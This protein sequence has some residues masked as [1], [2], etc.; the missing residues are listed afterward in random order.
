[1]VNLG[2]HSK[3]KSLDL[4][5]SLKMMILKVMILNEVFICALNA[6]PFY[7]LTEAVATTVIIGVSF[8]VSLS[9]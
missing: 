6:R 8:N 5:T 1:M 9:V 2:S 3:K 7:T 4:E